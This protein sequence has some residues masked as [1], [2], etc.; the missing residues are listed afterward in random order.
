MSAKKWAIFFLY[1]ISYGGCNAE[2]PEDTHDK[3]DKGLNA[4]VEGISAIE[5]LKTTSKDKTEAAQKAVK[6]IFPAKSQA[7]MLQ[8]VKNSVG[9][10]VSAIVKTVNVLTKALSAFSFAAAF[11]SFILAFI[12]QEDPSMNFMKEQFA[13]VN[14]KL[15]VISLEI[16]TL[17]KDVKWYSYASIYSQ[18]ENKIQNAWMKFN[19]FR[20]K[21]ILVKTSQEKTRLAEQFT[22]YFESTSTESSIENFYRYLTQKELSLTENLLDLVN[23]KFK[24][25]FNVITLFGAHFTALMFKGMQ[26]N[27][28]YYALKGYDG[29][30]KAKACV[31]KLANVLA[32]VE[33]AMTE[34]IDKY[35][36][37]AKIDVDEIGLSSWSDTKELASLIKNHLDKKFDWYEW[38]VIAYKNEARYEFAAGKYIMVKNIQNKA[39]VFI[40]HR[41]K[42]APINDQ[43]KKQIQKERIKR[44]CLSLGSLNPPPLS[45]AMFN[46]EQMSN[47]IAMHA[48]L[49]HKDY[50]Q[51]DNKA[52][53]QARCG[54]N[55]FTVILRGKEEALTPPCSKSPC[56]NGMCKPIPD[57]MGEYCSCSHLYYGQSCTRQVLD[58]IRWETIKDFIN[59]IT[60]QPVPDLTS[61][62]YS[63][64]NLED[65]TTLVAKSMESQIEWTQ[66]LVKYSSTISKLQ[67]LISQNK[68]LEDN[69]LSAVD[70]LH[71]MNQ[72]FCS[73]TFSFL[74]DN[75]NS[76]MMGAGFGDE[77]NILDMYRKI[78]LTKNPQSP[79]IAC[80]SDY[81][82]KIDTFVRY[83]FALQKESHLTWVKYLLLSEQPNK[84]DD[85][86][87][88]F[89]ITVFNQW[90]LFNKNGCGP[91]VAKSLVNNFCSELYHTTE[92]QEVKLSCGEKL[93]VFPITVKCSQGKWSAIPVC[94]AHPLNGITDCKTVG[95][96]TVC[97]MTCNSYW[98]YSD[99]TTEKTFTCNKP[100]CEA[101]NPR[102]CQN[103]LTHSV[104]QSNEVCNLLKKMCEDGCSSGNNPCGKNTVCTTVSNQQRCTCKSGWSGDDPRLGCTYANLVWT[105]TRSIPNTERQNY[106]EAIN[107]RGYFQGDCKTACAQGEEDM[108]KQSCAEGYRLACDDQVRSQRA[109]PQKVRLKLGYLKKMGRRANST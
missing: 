73:T 27:L 66:V 59:S 54:P 18:D 6:L 97:K 91:L 60:I 100:P 30:A 89:N 101:I 51:T 31:E 63:L 40:C 28:Y 8:T 85:A 37:Q 44:S 93:G 22:S 86:K 25:D 49:D 81:K 80:S 42:G 17:Q 3:V 55:M 57:T 95:T 50:N 106:V 32:A 108:G 98:A 23:E 45:E 26:L 46:N 2:L 61:I 12:P 13:E 47:I 11:I 16:S 56:E 79:V 92:G 103:C 35:E 94:Y 10:T 105:A 96:K 77:L 38:I 62:F 14:R 65:Y 88:Q 102:P 70:F 58:D 107:C 64:K 43:V 53:I 82:V 20:E 4:L 39:N 48:V 41:E 68:R 9:K 104:C 109:G 29:E 15:D 36:E 83:M 7:S 78:L 99:G 21:A 87:K 34:C 19:E 69:I 90:R 71:E 74:A 84:V 1:L 75:Y 76:M 52:M 67:F 72:Q 24:R 5:V 33:K